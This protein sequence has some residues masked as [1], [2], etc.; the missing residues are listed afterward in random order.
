MS[1]NA[2]AVCWMSLLA[3]AF[4]CSLALIAFMTRHDHHWER[5]SVSYTPGGSLTEA[6]SWGRSG[7]ELIRE[8]AL[9]VTVVVLRCTDC[10]AETDHRYIGDARS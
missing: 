2:V 8:L 7:R 6:T 5:H 10:G 1:D 3:V 9:G 4:L